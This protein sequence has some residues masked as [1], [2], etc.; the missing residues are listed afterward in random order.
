MLFRSRPKKEESVAQLDANT[1]AALEELEREL[2]TRVL[3]RPPRGKRA[4][5]LVVEYYDDSHLMGLYDRIL[6]RIN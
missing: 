1:R 4:G 3:L 2:G 6:R 5:Q